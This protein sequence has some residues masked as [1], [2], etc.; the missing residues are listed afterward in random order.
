[1]K[2]LMRLEAEARAVVEGQGS[3][4]TVADQMSARRFVVNF[5]DLAVAV[6][7]LRGLGVVRGHLRVVAI[8][9]VAH[10]LVRAAGHHRAQRE[11]QH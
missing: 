8:I 6:V 5:H 7:I 10:V 9:V 1:M 11:S 4:G 2:L 3:E